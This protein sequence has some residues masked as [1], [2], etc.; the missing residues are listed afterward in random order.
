MRVC[1]YTP[2]SRTFL[3]YFYHVLRACVLPLV[4]TLSYRCSYNR[5]DEY[6]DAP[7]FIGLLVQSGDATP[8]VIPH[9]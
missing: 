9:T 3:P 5:I 6:K 8:D 2:N 1:S 4:P 7:Y